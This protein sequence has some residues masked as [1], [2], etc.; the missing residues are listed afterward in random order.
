[1]QICLS[2]FPEGSELPCQDCLCW[3]LAGALA[4]APHG[5]CDCRQFARRSGNVHAALL[6]SSFTAL[7][8]RPTPRLAGAGPAF[9]DMFG[10]FDGH[11]G[12]P[13]AAFAAKHAMP[14]LLEE[15]QKGTHP[16]ESHP[17]DSHPGAAAAEGSSG[18][19]GGAGVAGLG[20][21]GLPG[22]AA[23]EA[24]EL[25][26]CKDVPAGDKALWASQDAVAAALPGALARTFCSVQ[27]QFF[28]GSKARPGR[29]CARPA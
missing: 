15:L 10:I 2:V 25:L 24:K 20:A 23:E 17:D 18:G 11:G 29:S 1:M 21:A 9:L 6:P 12:K 22:D 3:A 4:C 26:A 19:G 27:A 14:T 28:A 16:G 5:L 13:A 8:H 7:L